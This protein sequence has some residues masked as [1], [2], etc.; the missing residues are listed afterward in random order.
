MEIGADLSPLHL[1]GRERRESLPQRNL[2]WDTFASDY[3]ALNKDVC[4]NGESADK[5]VAFIA[6]L[7][8]L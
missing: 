6:L 8:R 3:L 4:L 7:G 2:N 5:A 1:G